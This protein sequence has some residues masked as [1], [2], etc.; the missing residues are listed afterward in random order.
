MPRLIGLFTLMLAT[1]ASADAQQNL[2]STVPTARD[3]ENVWTYSVTRRPPSKDSL[4]VQLAIP[5]S[6]LVVALT[7]ITEATL[8]QERLGTGNL[9][10]LTFTLTPAPAQAP[11]T[12]ASEYQT[13]TFEVIASQNLTAPGMVDWTI[14]AN[15]NITGIAPGPTVLYDPSILRAFLAAGGSWLRDDVVDFKIEDGDMLVE[16]NSQMRP[17]AVAGVLLKIFDFQTVF[18]WRL[19]EKKT[20]DFLLS[21]EFANAT[22]KTLDGFVFGLGFGVN[23]YLE[24]YGGVS[25]RTGQEI[26]DGFRKAA[27]QL[28]REI[29][30]LRDTDENKRIR[31]DFARFSK[32]AKDTSNDND[33]DGFPTISPITNEQFFP[34][35]PLINSTNSAWVVGVALPIDIF[36]LIRRQ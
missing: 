19:E 24:V 10:R 25:V 31:S 36:N 26:S 15:P 30:G 12:P 28:A 8:Q 16:N 13:F 9:I 21:L 6:A 34:G 5:E 18:G 35:T 29:R 7:P 17:S 23:Q 3:N 33:F 20:I 14:E 27:Q 1:L 11:A 4:T 2:T 22:S 32:L